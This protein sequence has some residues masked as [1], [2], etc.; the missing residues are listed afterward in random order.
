MTCEPPSGQP[1]GGFERDLGFPALS[2]HSSRLELLQR[3]FPKADVPECG[4]CQLSE[5]MIN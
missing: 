5:G 3:G 2:S 4:Q 1:G